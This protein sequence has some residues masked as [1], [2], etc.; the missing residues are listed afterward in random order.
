MKD[1]GYIVVRKPEFVGQHFGDAPCDVEN[2]RHKQI[3]YCGVCR[4]PWWDL[5]GLFYEDK[6]S[7]EEKALRNNIVGLKMSFFYAGICADLECAQKALR[8]SNRERDINEIVLLSNTQPAGEAVNMVLGAELL[9]LDYYIDGYGSVI[10]SGIFA[11]PAAFP[12]TVE[13]LNTNGLFDTQEDLENYLELYSKRCRVENLEIID[14]EKM[15]G[16]S[17]LVYRLR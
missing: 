4:D 14:R 8:L 3:R 10:R 9:G 12:E 16:S 1:L 17:F 11:K 6:L 7:E 5:N 13:V 15:D 2:A